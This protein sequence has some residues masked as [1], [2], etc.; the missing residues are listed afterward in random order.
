VEETRRTR[1]IFSW[2]DHLL[3]Q[4]WVQGDKYG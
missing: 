4:L 2:I 1:P 3:E